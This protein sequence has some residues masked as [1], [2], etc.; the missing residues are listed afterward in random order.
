MEITLPFTSLRP[1]LNH[2][3]HI[4]E[5]AL[6]TVVFV[7]CDHVPSYNLGVPLPLKEGTVNIRRQ[8]VISATS[9]PKRIA[10]IHISTSSLRESPHFMTIFKFWSALSIDLRGGNTVSCLFSYLQR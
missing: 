5:R 8:L 3:S 2:L 1:E 9:P 4:A 7:L 10:S 6:R